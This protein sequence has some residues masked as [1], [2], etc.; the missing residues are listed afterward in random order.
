MKVRCI[1]LGEKFNEW[2]LEV[3]HFHSPFLSKKSRKD[4]RASVPHKVSGARPLGTTDDSQDVH[5]ITNTSALDMMALINVSNRMTF[6]RIVVKFG[7][8]GS[9][10]G[11]KAG[12]V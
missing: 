10:D 9:D 3:C 11:R 2:D 6:A 4:L 5:K 1:F 7:H 12:S 8:Y